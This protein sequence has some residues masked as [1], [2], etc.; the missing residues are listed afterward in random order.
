MEA[1]LCCDHVGVLV[2]DL[3]AAL[4]SLGPLAVQAH[5]V[6]EFPGE[7]TREVYVGSGSARL[8][9]LQP[10]GAGPYRRALNARGPG[11]HHLALS[12]PDPRALLRGLPGWLL[13]P[14]SLESGPDTLWACRPGIPLLLELAAGA[15]TGPAL[16]TRLEVPCAPELAPLLA[17]L[18][19]PRSPVALG[20]R[21]RLVLAGRGW[22]PVEL[23]LEG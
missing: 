18:Q 12:G 7:G 4:E 10:L 6:Q 20:A 8:L 17:R 5:P 22:D 1:S 2:R 21:S 23:T 13:H 15:A 3:E 19:G 16:V 14:Y 11:V 9:L